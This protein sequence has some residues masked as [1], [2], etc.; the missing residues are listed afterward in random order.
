MLDHQTRENQ[1]LH[2]MRHQIPLDSESTPPLQGPCQHYETLG[3]KTKIS[4]KRAVLS[5]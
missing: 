1:L 5:S 2:G 3:V 4:D